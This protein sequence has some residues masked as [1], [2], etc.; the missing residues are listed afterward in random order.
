MKILSNIYAPSEWIE[1]RRQGNV[2]CLD[3]ERRITRSIF[4][5]VL[6]IHQLVIAILNNESRFDQNT[7]SFKA[8]VPNMNFF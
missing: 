2:A 4:G 8:N 1:K 5:K 6:A 3:L 7:T